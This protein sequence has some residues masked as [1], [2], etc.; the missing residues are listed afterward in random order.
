VKLINQ[1][2]CATHFFAVAEAIRFAERH[3]VDR[4]K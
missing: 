4:A 3:G 1:I 2:L